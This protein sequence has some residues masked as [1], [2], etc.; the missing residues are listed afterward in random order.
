MKENNVY[1]SQRL[2]TY[3]DKFHLGCLMNYDMITVN[4]DAVWLEFTELKDNN[5]PEQTLSWDNPSYLWNKLYHYLENKLTFKLTEEQLKEFKDVDEYM[6]ID[7]CL[8][9]LELLNKAKTLNWY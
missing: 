2:A 7:N 1:L 5:Y 9:L 3:S 8:D 4:K 6:N